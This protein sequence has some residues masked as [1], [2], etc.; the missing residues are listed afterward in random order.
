MGVGAGG[1][2]FQKHILFVC[3]TSSIRSAYI[4]ESKLLKQVKKHTHVL[5]YK[6]GERPETTLLQAPGPEV[7]KTLNLRLQEEEKSHHCL[8]FFLFW[9]YSRQLWQTC[10]YSNHMQLNV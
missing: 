10:A 1:W 2:M 8:S 4:L 6:Q 3:Y 5:I 7:S 9:I